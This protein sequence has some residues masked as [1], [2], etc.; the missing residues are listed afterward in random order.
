MPVDW[1]RLRLGAMELIGTACEAGPEAARRPPAPTALST[2][3]SAT[4]PQ[5]P[6]SMQ[7]PT[8]LAVR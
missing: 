8:H 3:T 2:V 5:V 7:R 6:H 1:C 4:L